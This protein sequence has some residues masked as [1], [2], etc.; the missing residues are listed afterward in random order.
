MWYK[1]LT[2]SFFLAALLSIN[3]NCSRSDSPP[4][5]GTAGDKIS[6]WVTTGDKSALLQKQ[7]TA[8]Q[9]GDVSNSS[10]TIQVDSAQALQSVDGFGYTLTGGSAYLIN[11][12]NANDKAALL[13]ELFGNGDNSLGVSYLR[14]SIGA[15][16]L[17]AEV[18]S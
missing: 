1:I 16:D 5:G 7:T 6:Y 14:V 4:G 8:L 10:P 2:F 13:Q 18:F 17:N 3:S 15:S 11:K 12:L 9:F